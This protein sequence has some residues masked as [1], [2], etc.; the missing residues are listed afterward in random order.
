MSD[1]VKRP[2]KQGWLWAV[3]AV[4]ATVL[5]SVPP[6]P[7]ESQMVFGCMQGCPMVYGWMMYR[8]GYWYAF[9]SCMSFGPLWLCRY[10]R[11]DGDTCFCYVDYDEF[12]D[13]VEM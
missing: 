10:R 2:R 5:V 6:K 9:N 1:S 13:P 11:W 7:A 3:L 4:V 8:D 12:T